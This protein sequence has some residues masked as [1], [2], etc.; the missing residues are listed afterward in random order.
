MLFMVHAGKVGQSSSGSGS[1]RSSA[2]LMERFLLIGVKAV[3]ADS[4]STTHAS[5]PK[6][7]DPVLD[8]LTGVSGAVSLAPAPDSADMTA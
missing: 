5:L 1:L 3:P 8:G 7:L 2:R 6:K 4:S